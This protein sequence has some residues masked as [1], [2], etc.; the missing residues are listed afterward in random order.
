LALSDSIRRASRNPGAAAFALILLAL[1]AIRVC[2]LIV[3]P[4][5]LG[6]PDSSQYIDA[7]I[8][9]LDGQPF[10]PDPIRVMGTYSF[11]LYLLGKTLGL[12]GVAV[13]LVQ[14][15]LG[16][17]TALCVFYI[18]KTLTRS[19]AWANFALL[20]TGMLPRGWF[21]EH[22]IIA[23]CLYAFLFVGTCV[24]ALEVYRKPNAGRALLFGLI[25]ALVSLARAQ[26]F[27]AIPFGLVL[28]AAAL[29]NHPWKVWLGRGAGLGALYLLPIV[30][31]IG[32][33]LRANI[34]RNH[35]HGLSASGNY[36]LMWLSAGNLIDYEKPTNLD[37]KAKLRPYVER[38]NQQLASTPFTAF[39]FLTNAQFDEMFTMFFTYY[40]HNWV[41]LNQKMGELTR[42][43]I[44]AHPMAFCHRAILQLKFFFFENTTYFKLGEIAP[45][46]LKGDKNH[47]TVETAAAD[48]LLKYNPLDRLQMESGL[49]RGLNRFFRGFER[50]AAAQNII[51]QTVYQLRVLASER[52]YTA[53]LLLA[54]AIAAV[55][56]WTG[57]FYF[58]W[59]ATLLLAQ[60]FVTAAPVF[61][62]HDR[63]YLPSEPLQIML[64]ALALG[65]PAAVPWRRAL[66]LLAGIG[67]ATLAGTLLGRIIPG[68][69]LPTIDRP[70]LAYTAE[71]TLQSKRAFYGFLFK[72]AFALVGG[73]VA[74]SRFSTRKRIPSG[75]GPNSVRSFT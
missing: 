15:L 6:H 26:G 47:F 50:P 10:T 45:F 23:D 1:V 8:K 4:F 38:S 16:I 33:Y 56:A 39:M 65:I 9:M 55:Q 27:V 28:I 69:W 31:F 21:L 64:F 32:L 20:F 74:F 57:V 46:F 2:F 19:W 3:W 61:A 63:Y 72:A 73:Y 40:E 54:L 60:I 51:S 48:D 11:F 25:V 29:W 43:A 34:N 67:L 41:K 68:S 44:W 59:V 24:V 7:A 42:E 30:L 13:A 17:G 70:I 53:M 14:H 5:T 22:I 37:I 49:L 75:Q 62:L 18:V 12:T 71:A 52:L 66:L 35:F 58:F 36:N